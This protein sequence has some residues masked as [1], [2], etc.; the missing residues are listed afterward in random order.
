MSRRPDAGRSHGIF[1]Q[2]TE[3]AIGMK[4]TLWASLAATAVVAGLSISAANAGP[5]S[6]LDTLKAEGES[7][8]L[9]EKT[10]GIHR[11][12]EW[13]RYRGWHRSYNRWTSSSCNPGPSWRNQGRCWIG[14]RGVR[15]CRFYG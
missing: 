3:K 1:V 6:M 13:S 4:R 12:C 8:N 10:H 2:P 14:P 9:V 11:N 15:H 5:A 7:A